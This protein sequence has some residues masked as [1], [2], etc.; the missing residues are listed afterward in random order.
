MVRVIAVGIVAGAALI[1][2]RAQLAAQSHLWGA[3]CAIALTGIVVHFFFRRSRA[4]RVL[5]LGLAAA[6]LSMSWTVWQ[7]QGRLADALSPA[8]ED[9]VSRL[10]FRVV[11]M[12]QDQSGSQRFEAQ[13]QEPVPA[14]IPR[15]I[16]VVWAQPYSNVDRLPVVLP[17]QTWRAALV[18]RHPHG[19][20]NPFG[21][22]YEGW[23]F[24][25]NVRAIGKVRGQPVLLSDQPFGSFG[26]AVARTRHTMRAAMRRAVGDLRYG[27]VM[28]ALAIGDQDSVRV[29]DWIVFNQT[30]ITH[31]VS[32]SGSHV[33]MLAAF[34]ALAM[35]WCWKRLQVRGRPVCERVPA[36]VAGA[37][38]ALLVA[39]LYCLL[40]GWGVPARR[41]F[42]MLAVGALAVGTRWPI[43]PS[44]IVCLAAA[45]VMLADP[46]ASQSTGFWLSFGAVAVLFGAA[47]QAI[48]M[49]GQGT[50]VTKFWVMFKEAARLQWLITLAMLPVLAFLF[51]QAS[52]SS[53]FANAV[54]IPVVTFIVTPLALLTACLCVIPGLEVFASS[55]GWLGHQA[56]LWMMMPVAGL[57][58]L[59]WSTFD[60][61]A[62]PWGLLLL[63]LAGVAWA[64]Q[65]PGVPVRWAGWCLLGPA[66]AW[67]PERPGVGAWRLWALDVGQGSAVLI[68]T[69]AHDVLVDTG[70]TLGASDAGQ[71]VIAPVLRALGVD[72][73]HTVVV[74]HADL[75]H[76]GGLAGVLNGVPVERTYAS[77]DVE[78]LLRKRAALTDRPDEVRRPLH[79]SR[80]VRG[81]S[82]QLDGVRFSFL[83]PETLNPRQGEKEGNNTRSCVLLVAGQYHS[84]LLPGDIG[85][86]QERLMPEA[87]ADVV[88]VAHHG[89]SSSSGTQ[90]V[91]QLGA[92][93]AIAQLGHFNRFGHPDKL[94]QERWQ[95]SGASFWRTDL[96][97]A[98]QVTS[99]PQ[100]LAVQSHRQAHARYWHARDGQGRQSG[101]A[102]NSQTPLQ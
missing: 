38:A 45:V 51:Q 47:G 29:E 60:V 28:I 84:V 22:D 14:G 31:L 72:R 92:R 42:F 17:G 27:A 58:A 21:F 83:H 93:I 41:T 35:V 1:H 6:L 80:C 43:A 26:V 62:V 19:A 7:A 73:L 40:A 15:H 39:W 98:V 49:V 13:V 95:Q 46:W 74:S 48:R 44:R 77:F 94:V 10:T 4:L 12:A 100:G 25:R 79:T 3:L 67:H 32:I 65:P 33:T 90:F 18:L 9:R 61:A 37:L 86:R 78:A 59:S 20:S 87:R 55:M 91:R 76:T 23:M 71:R 68:S 34:G 97:G 66:L 70:P 85:V 57:A 50:G 24:Q 16:Q 5:L 54:A 11:T 102:T 2:T 30:G 36:R 89:S 75:D 101:Q 63:A 64:L 53:P 99:G 56:L 82:W 96:H 81:L 8:H 69:H 52:L 88:V